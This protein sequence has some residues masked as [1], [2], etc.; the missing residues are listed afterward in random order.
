M[1]IARFDHVYL[2]VDDMDRAVAFYTQLLGMAP[3]HREENTWTDFGCSAGPYL[4]L[5]ERN[6]L[7]GVRG[8]SAVAVLRTDDIAEARV[9]LERMDAAI[10][11]PPMNVPTS[12]RYRYLWCRD[13]EGNRIEVAEYDRNL[14]SQI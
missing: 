8:D 3:C 1:P 6:A 11:V 12:Y 10:E 9:A 14:K 7:D 13:P 2:P 4:G 5:I